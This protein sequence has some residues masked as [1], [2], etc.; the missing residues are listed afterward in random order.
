MFQF[1]FQL[2]LGEEL[3][4]AELKAIVPIRVKVPQQPNTTDCGLYPGHFL[5]VFLSNPE[6]YTAHCRGET[7]MNGTVDEI[8]QAGSIETTRRVLLSLVN[9]ATRYRLAAM[10][11]DS[12]LSPSSQLE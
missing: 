3:R 8:W 10:S 2:A 6:A 9:M 1:V 12:K 4:L 5:S 11:F 7:V